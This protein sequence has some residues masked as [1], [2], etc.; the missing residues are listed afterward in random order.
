MIEVCTCARAYIPPE[1]STEIQSNRKRETVAARI[2]AKVN[3]DFP[4][5]TVSLDECPFRKAES[6]VKKKKRN[7]IFCIYISIL[8]IKVF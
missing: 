5:R 7:V 1:S 2:Y 3:R 4:T 6:N 8:A